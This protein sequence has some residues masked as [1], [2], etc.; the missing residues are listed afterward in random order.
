[1][2]T[3]ARI[4]GVFYLITFVMGVVALT[5]VQGKVAAKLIASVSYVAV[6]VLFYA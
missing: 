4:A 3:Q 6:A 5:S 1:M 2:R